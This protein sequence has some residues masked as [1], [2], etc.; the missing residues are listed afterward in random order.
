ML[1]K[2]KIFEK[3]RGRKLD[4]RIQKTIF[5]LKLPNQSFSFHS[6]Y[7]ETIFLILMKKLFVKAFIVCCYFCYA[8]QFLKIVSVI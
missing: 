3:W 6:F 1:R 5:F 7:W 2:S 8:T 4:E